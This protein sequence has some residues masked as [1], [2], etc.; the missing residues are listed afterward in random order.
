MVIVKE[1]KNLNIRGNI[2]K[3]TRKIINGNGVGNKIGNSCERIRDE[4]RI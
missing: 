2:R 1:M 3:G 4:K